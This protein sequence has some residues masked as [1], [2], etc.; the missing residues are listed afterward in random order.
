MASSFL[1]PAAFAF[2]T[3]GASVSMKNDTRS[4]TFPP[5]MSRKRRKKKLFAASV[6]SGAVSRS[7][8]GCAST[9][10]VTDVFWSAVAD[11][12]G[13]RCRTEHAHHHQRCLSHDRHSH[14]LH[15]CVERGCQDASAGRFPARAATPGKARLASA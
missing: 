9:P 14:C 1:R 2:P 12:F 8:C 3:L 15:L 5:K 10:K 7:T 6:L 11:R 13:A 4:V